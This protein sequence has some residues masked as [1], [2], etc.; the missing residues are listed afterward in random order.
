MNPRCAVPAKSTVVIECDLLDLDPQS[1]DILRHTFSNRL[2]QLELRGASEDNLP[3]N[4]SAGPRGRRTLRV[5]VNGGAPIDAGIVLP[6]AVFPF[7][8]L[9]WEGDV[10]T[11][12]GVERFNAK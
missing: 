9:S 10:I 12:K 3:A 11:L 2:H 7:V 4:F 8:M 5:S 6:Q 1:V